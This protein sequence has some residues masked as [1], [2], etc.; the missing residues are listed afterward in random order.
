[1]LLAIPLNFLK[2]WTL[3]KASKLKY[4][5]SGKVGTVPLLNTDYSFPSQFL[6]HIWYWIV[7][8]SWGKD[9]GEQGYLKIKMG[10]NLCGELC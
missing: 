8:N 10:D 5:D 7:R 9:Y 1:M 2:F 4:S 6:G 3:A